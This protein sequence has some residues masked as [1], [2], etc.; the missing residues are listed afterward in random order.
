MKYIKHQHVLSRIWKAGM[1]CLNSFFLDIVFWMT[2]SQIGFEIL[3]SGFSLYPKSGRV[4]APVGTK[5]VYSTCSAQKGQIT[6]LVAICASGR[7][8]FLCIYFLK[9]AFRIILWRAECTGLILEDLMR[10]GLTLIFLWLDKKKITFLSR[11][12][13]EGLLY[14]W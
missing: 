9:S 4:L 6:T 2:Y 5:V 12:V 14:C 10:V 8:I 1:L 3:M 7:T 13:G 11:L